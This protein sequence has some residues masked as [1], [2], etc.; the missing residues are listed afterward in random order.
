MKYFNVVGFFFVAY[1]LVVAYSGACMPEEEGSSKQ[2]DC[3]RCRCRRGIWLCTKKGC[4]SNF[5]KRELPIAA[6]LRNIPCAPNDYFQIDCNTCYCNLEQSGYLCT[7]N[8]CTGDDHVGPSTQIPLA[9]S[10]IL[11][12][13]NNTAQIIN[14]ASDIEDNS[15][16]LLPKIDVTVL[17]DKTRRHPKIFSSKAADVK[18]ST[19]A[20]LELF[21]CTPGQVFK[22]DCN[23]C[24]CTQDGKN[25]ICTTKNCSDPTLQLAA[26]STPTTLLFSEEPQAASSTQS[27]SP[28]ATPSTTPGNLTGAENH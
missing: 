3:N 25:A 20:R 16:S 7:E 23:D 17:K 22:K 28:G 18:N 21:S 2:L 11:L 15:T 5:F 4:L 12:I 8:I 13:A 24:K 14:N 1:L 10:S 6:D 27:S 19:S 26:P 9:N